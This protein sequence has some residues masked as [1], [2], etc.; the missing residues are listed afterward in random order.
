M[1]LVTLRSGYRPKQN[2]PE[3]QKTEHWGMENVDWCISMYPLTLHDK[4]KKLYNLYNGI[5]DEDKFKHIEETYGIE[6]PAGKV[7]HIPLIRPLLNVL[8]GEQQ[9]RPLTY[10]VRSEDNDSVNHKLDEISNRMLD[11]LVRLI[12]S[13]APIDVALDELEKYYRE[14]FQ[15]KLEIASHNA[16]QYFVQKHHLEQYFNDAFIDKIITGTQYYRI[17]VNRIGEDPLFETIRPGHLF[18]SNDAVKWVKECSWAVYPIRMSPTEILDVYGERMKSEEVKQLEDWVDMYYK[19]SYKLKEISEADRLIEN[20]DD[21]RSYQAALYNTITVYHVE[22]KSIREVNLMVNENKYSPKDPWMKYI[23]QE[24][25]LEMESNK[26]S[27]LQ[28]VQKRYVQDLWRG[29]RIG[30]N[31]YVDIGR[32][33]YATRSR[34]NPSKV[35]LSFNGPTY[36]GRI[37]AYSLVDATSDIQDLYD[38]LHYHKE[39]LIAISG[40][41]GS[42]MDFT[43][44][45]DFG[46]G[47]FVKN[48]KMWMYYK[49]LG[50][51]WL[52][53]GQPNVDRT[54][55]QFSTYDDTLGA[56]LEAV[57]AMI[58]HLEQLAGRVIGVNNQRLGAISQR[59]GK[60]VTE[61]AIFQSNLVTEPIFNDH[62]E[63]VRQSLED[64]I[65]ACRIAWR[66]GMK[67]TFINDQ[68]LMQ[69]FTLEPDFSAADLGVYIT[70]RISE[71]RSIDELKVMVHEFVRQGVAEME[72]IFP[73]FRKTNLK[74]LEV[75]VLAGQERRKK[76]MQAQQ[77]QIQKM[78]DLV[79]QLGIAKTQKEVEK[80]EAEINNLL[81]TA[82]FNKAKS[83]S[84]VQSIDT[85]KQKVQNDSKRV[86][87]EAKQLEYASSK[88][89][90]E[91]KNK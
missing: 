64:I 43:Q 67:G 40:V 11:E 63:F 73:F 26:S 1:S 56:G 38:V 62:D 35:Y 14:N 80:L 88:N 3:S 13:D 57:L 69:I 6:F 31:I 74:D 55:N 10:T 70:N 52:D 49:K 82:D 9:E 23:S 81:A 66:N 24:K 46:T 17:R 36:N 84:E 48:L 8:I 22:W 86:D 59:E 4:F 7:K 32:V 83:Q 58:Q 30:D 45:P 21:F 75:T 42:Y 90:A 76:Q 60:G 20:I 51:A 29:T 34:S 12:R 41:K 25:V 37:A 15:T 39:N 27:R 44:I 19:D 87:L 65:N 28:K 68:Y 47:D 61:Q 53:R 33:K 78:E 50:V 5:R 79:R 77:E 72:Q 85:E 18:Y 16:L 54:F 91:I 89:A 71:Q 2:V